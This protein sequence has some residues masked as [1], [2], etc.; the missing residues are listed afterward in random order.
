MAAP[1]TTSAASLEKQLYEVALA[2]VQ[3]ELA[4]PAEERPDN[5][6]VTYDIEGGTVAIA[7]T[8]NTTLI[9]N[10]STAEITVNDY[11]V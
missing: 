6:T 9:A 2:L 10:G 5:A 11:L 8:L 7:A 1:I 4:V 3:A